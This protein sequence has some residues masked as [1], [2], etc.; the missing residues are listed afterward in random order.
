[1]D[2]EKHR[3]PD[4]RKIKFVAAGILCFVVGYILSIGPA[5]KM[6]DYGLIGETGD[7]VLG[8]VYA[9]LELI[10]RIPG[11]NRLWD[12]YIFGVWK[13]DPMTTR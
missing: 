3:L 9:P 7:K 6:E 11:S 13:C 10:G 5:A 4:S 8:Q 12:W 1:M 2:T